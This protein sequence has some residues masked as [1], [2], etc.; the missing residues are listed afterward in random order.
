MKHPIIMKISV[1]KYLKFIIV[2]GVLTVFTS[3]SEERESVKVERSE[4]IESVYSSVV[5][6]PV[7]MYKVNSLI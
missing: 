6:E 4:I 3:C 1:K 7:D 2:F 5:I